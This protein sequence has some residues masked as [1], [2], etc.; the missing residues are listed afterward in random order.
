[1]TRKDSKHAHSPDSQDT[2]PAHLS[3]LEEN[4]LKPRDVNRDAVFGDVDQGPQY[5]SVSRLTNGK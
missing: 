5:R 2:G 4:E 1:M 3:E